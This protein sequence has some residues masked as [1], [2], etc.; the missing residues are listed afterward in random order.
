MAMTKLESLLRVVLA[1]IGNL[2]MRKREG[3]GGAVEDVAVVFVRISL[4]R[5]RVS[6]LRCVCVCVYE[7]WMRGGKSG[8][9]GG[10]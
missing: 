2:E 1:R 4:M 6:L 8:E 5:M 9:E 7:V 3:L 10:W